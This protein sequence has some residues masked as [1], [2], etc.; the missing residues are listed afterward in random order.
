MRTGLFTSLEDLQDNMRAIGYVTGLDAEVEELITE[1]Q[2]K[3][4]KVAQRAD[5]RRSWRVLDLNAAMYTSGK[6]STLDGVL[7]YVG[8]RNTAVE[9]GVGEYLRVDIEQVLDWD[10]DVLIV[11][12]EPGSE[13]K[14]RQ[15][16]LQNPGLRVLRCVKEDRILFVSGALLGST[17]HH[18]AEAAVAIAE[19]LDRWGSR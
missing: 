10:P 18:V 15:R 9:M 14:E 2:E 8:A 3:L 5:E 12:A 17:S 13:E 7:T 11:P 6:G 16:I 19:Q 4:D 1:M